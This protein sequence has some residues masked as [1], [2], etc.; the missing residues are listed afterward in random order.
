VSEKRIGLRVVGTA[1]SPSPT[2]TTGS[3]PKRSAI[4]KPPATELIGPHGTPAATMRSNHSSA[5]RVDSALIRIGRSSS[6]F[7]VRSALRAKRGSSASSGRP[8]TWQSLRNCPSLAAATMRS[9][10][11]VGNGSYGT[12]LG[13]ALP[14][15]CGTT[16]PAT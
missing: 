9:L 3:S 11:A 12:T 16:P 4:A 10:S 2:V 7:V 1:R 5:P 14:M 13:C 6:R 15:R 8:S